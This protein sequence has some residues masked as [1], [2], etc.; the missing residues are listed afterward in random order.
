MTRNEHVLVLPEESLAVH[1]TRF[2]PIGKSE[3]EGG[4]HTTGTVPSQLSNA[5]SALKFTIASQRFGV[6]WT[7]T[8]AGQTNCGACVSSTT[9]RNAQVLVF[10]AASVATQFTT[11]VPFENVEPDGGVQTTVGVPQLSVAPA[12]NVTTAEHRPGSALTTRSAGQLITGRS[13]SKTITRKVQLALL[14]SVSVAVHTTELVP[15]GNVVPG[16][17]E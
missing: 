3:P 6:A 10:P 8:F 11:F 4:L 15:I 13:V 14:P 9:T 1:W 12:A 17:T 2:V 5:E 7:I 16:S